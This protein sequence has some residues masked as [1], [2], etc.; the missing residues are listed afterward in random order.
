M[1]FRAAPDTEYSLM[2]TSRRDGGSWL[3]IDFVIRE[4]AGT[5][6]EI[7]VMLSRARTFV[8][9][10]HSLR[11]H[12][13]IVE[14]DPQLFTIIVI[15]ILIYSLRWNWYIFFGER[16]I[17][18]LEVCAEYFGRSR[19]P[20]PL[21]HFHLIYLSQS[22]YKINKC[23]N[24]SNIDRCNCK[25]IKFSKFRTVLILSLVFLEFVVK[26]FDEIKMFKFNMQWYTCTIESI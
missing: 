1:S 3:K 2:W 16:A 18:L 25:N 7:G 9:T 23:T 8:M 24:I 20:L 11:A 19:S 21:Y 22:A 13:P 14:V 10:W 26:R 17:P 12:P 15:L 5:C 6:T 4:L